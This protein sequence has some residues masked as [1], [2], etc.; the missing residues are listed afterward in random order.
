MHNMI[1]FENLNLTCYFKVMLTVLTICNVKP[2]KMLNTICYIL[3]VVD[4]VFFSFLQVFI[5]KLKHLTTKS[6]GKTD[7][8]KASK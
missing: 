2:G 1:W 8:F 7:V 5:I 6:K 4:I 3:R